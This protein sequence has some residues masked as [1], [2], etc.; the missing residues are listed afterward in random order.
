MTNN[1][2]AQAQ[3]APIDG[4]N[5]QGLQRQY[6]EW[7]LDWKRLWASRDGARAG[8]SI[9]I[10]AA[11]FGTWLTANDQGAVGAL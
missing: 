1:I 3:K 11:S 8:A 5:S 2:K 4:T 9:G 7:G 10:R 6:R